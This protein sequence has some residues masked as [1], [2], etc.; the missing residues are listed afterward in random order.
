MIVSDEEVLT[1]RLSELKG[2]LLKQNYPQGVIDSGIQRAINLNQSELRRLRKR[3]EERV[4]TFVSRF[5]PKNSELCNAIRQN[6]TILLEDVKMREILRRNDIIRSKRQPPNLKILLTRA[7]FD[8][9]HRDKNIKKMQS[10]Q[11]WNLRVLNSWQCI[12]L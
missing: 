5:N 3:L 7:R 12:F 2:A 4:V 1:R 9:N 10:P 8:E 6:M 11:L